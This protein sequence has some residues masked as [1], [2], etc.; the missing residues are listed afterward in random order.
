MNETLIK[1]LEMI[2]FIGFNPSEEYLGEI[3]KIYYFRYY[4]EYVDNYYVAEILKPNEFDLLIRVSIYNREQFLK[5]PKSK[6][7]SPG[8]AIV[9]YYSSNN[10]KDSEK[11]FDFM[12]YE[13][14]YKMKL[15][16]H[17][18]INLID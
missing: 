7:W 1:F 16:D 5:I 13:F 4:P 9:E 2:K 10:I 14:S 12:E 11:L 3:S 17:K 15:R 6:V 18:L 8:D